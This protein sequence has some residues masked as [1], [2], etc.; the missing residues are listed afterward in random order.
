MIARIISPRELVRRLTR[1]RD[2]A[3]DAKLAAREVDSLDAWRGSDIG[4]RFADNRGHLI[5]SDDE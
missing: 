3:R 5:D 4:E 2:A 1:D